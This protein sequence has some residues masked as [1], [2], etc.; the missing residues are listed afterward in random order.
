M[1]GADYTV[2]LFD[3]DEPRLEVVEDGIAVY[4]DW[5][6]VC[7][8]YGRGAML[9]VD[10]GSAPVGAAARNA[11]QG[12]TDDPVSAVVL[13][14]GHADHTSGTISFVEG[15]DP[16]PDVW[17]HE[18][19]L[20]RTE[21][22]RR[23]KGWSA[24]V[25]RHQLRANQTHYES[26]FRAKRVLP[27]RTYRDRAELEIAGERFELHHAEA[28][29]DDHTWVWAP[30]RGVAIVG[31]LV[32]PSFPNAGNPNKVQRYVLGWAETLD[33]IAAR[34]PR[35]V[36]PAHGP[37][38]DAHRA[39]HVLPR[40][41]ESLRHVHDTVLERMNAGRWPWQVLEDPITLPDHLR[42]EPY[43]REAYGAVSFAVHDVLRA[44]GGWWSGLPADLVEVPQSQRATDLVDLCGI[45]IVIGRARALLAEGEPSRA[46]ALA[47]TAVLADPRHPQARATYVACLHAAAERQ[48]SFIARNLL[49]S[50]ADDHDE[51]VEGA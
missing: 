49:A 37:P 5:V 22:Y 21:R 30:D 10:T 18:G 50:I 9:V 51:P 41:A 4:R 8:I 12:L 7:A 17:A 14:H 47:Q 11:L 43:L 2:E 33:A 29:T 25:N 3:Q 28:E 39:A 24:H 46:V 32:L 26:I 1:A 15:L 44:Y 36:L 13:T 40:I 27:N 23:T 20:T 45:E 6:N 34:E 19:V 31:D 16:T 35:W 42:D 38:L 48:P